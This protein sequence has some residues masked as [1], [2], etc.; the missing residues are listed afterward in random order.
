MLFAGVGGVGA[1]GKY[2]SGPH[3]GERTQR[4]VGNGAHDEELLC[5]PVGDPFF[6]N[7]SSH[8]THIALNVRKWDSFL[9]LKAYATL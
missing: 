1:E 5:D 4:G 3:V 7:C 9:C 2:P 8:F 6:K